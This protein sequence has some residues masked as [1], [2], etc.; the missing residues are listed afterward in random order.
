MN[1]SNLYKHDINYNNNTTLYNMI[2]HDFTI[3]A[4][5]INLDIFLCYV[6]PKGTSL[7]GFPFLTMQNSILQ[8]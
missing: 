3:F 5:N 7:F 8:K 4:L 1:H 6:V 2:H